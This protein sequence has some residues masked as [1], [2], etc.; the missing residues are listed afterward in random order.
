MKNKKLSDKIAMDFF[1]CMVKSQLNLEKCLQKTTV[2]A[3]LLY[4]QDM[5]FNVENSSH[6]NTEIFF[7]SIDLIQP[8]IGL[9]PGQSTVISSFDS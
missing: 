3:F 1:R 2:N 5:F 7:E 9:L 8:E 6:Q 4:A